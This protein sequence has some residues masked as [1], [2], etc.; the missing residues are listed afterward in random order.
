[1]RFAV[2]FGIAI[3]I[4][5]ASHPEPADLNA[6]LFDDDRLPGIFGRAPGSSKEKALP[7]QMFKSLT[8]PRIAL[9]K[10]VIVGEGDDF[11]SVEL[12]RLQ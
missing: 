4:Q 2:L 11:N 10:D 7:A 12:Q 8:K 9:V 3:A 6:V 5:P 1:M